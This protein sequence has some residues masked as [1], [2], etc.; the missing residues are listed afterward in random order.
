MPWPLAPCPG[1]QALCFVLLS[2]CRPVHLSLNTLQ[3]SSGNCDVMLLMCSRSLMRGC[4]CDAPHGRGLCSHQCTLAAV[5][6]VGIRRGDT[7]SSMALFVMR[8]QQIA[9]HHQQYVMLSLPPNHQ[10]ECQ[11]WS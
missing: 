5:V 8:C 1:L 11:H 9:M 2:T 7:I 4:A 10:W 6:H 3:A